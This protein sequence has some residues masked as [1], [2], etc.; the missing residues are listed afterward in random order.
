MFDGRS[1]LNTN[2][3]RGSM[4]VTS[5][6][7][8]PNTGNDT[9]TVTQAGIYSADLGSGNDSF[10]DAYP[11]VATV[12]GGNGNDTVIDYY[13]GSSVDLGAGNDSYYSDYGYGT[14]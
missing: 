4:P 11:G 1:K 3:R 12:L 13:G 10:Y 14:A 2:I 9:V 6:T 7:P 5:L 8:S